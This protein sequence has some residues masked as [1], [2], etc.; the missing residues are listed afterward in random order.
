MNG[1]KIRGT[2]RCVPEHIITNE[3]LAQQMDTSDEWITSRT[4]IRRRHHCTGESTSGLCA[5]AA[6]AALTKAGVS[7][8]QIGACIV[9]TV[10]PEA[11]VPSTACVLQRELGLP[12]DIPCF[13]LN[14]ACTGFLFALHTMECLLNASPRK[15]GLVVGGEALSRR[16]NW[17][18]RGTC[19]LFGD[20]AGAAVVECRE[21]WPSIGA[22]LGCHGDDEL[23]HLAGPGSEEP[24]L[25]AMEGT[26][27][28]KFA[29]QAV[30]WCI[31]RVLERH[32]MTMEEVDFF[33]FH[34]ANARIIDLAARKYAIPPEKYYKNLDE[35]GNTSAASI[36]LVLSE[37]EEQGKV[38]PGSRVVV[39]GFG[40]GLTWGG[41]LVE[42]V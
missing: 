8:D 29:V 5:E 11:L 15:F 17:D 25:I 2:G 31:D 1:I 19:I 10:T 33:V 30:P 7:P 13:D 28:F 14:A 35:Y 32:G 3:M 16:I 24:G 34:Q 26:K 4:G 41:A 22:V 20:G 9:A 18:D 12:D 40:G 37:L 36:P 27:V 21:G 38:G 6:R 42:F 23:L 39:V